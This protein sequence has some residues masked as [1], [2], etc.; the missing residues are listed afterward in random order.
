MDNSSGAL[1]S[2]QEWSAGE[3]LG[4]Q[5]DEHAVFADEAVQAMHA[6]TKDESAQGA[7]IDHSEVAE[8]QGEQQ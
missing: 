6:G 8:Q 2:N 5:T 7:P 3:R 4:W 1:P